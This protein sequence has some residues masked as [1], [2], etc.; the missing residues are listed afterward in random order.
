LGINNVRRRLDLA[1]P[2]RYLLVFKDEGDRYMVSMH[3]N[4]NDESKLFHN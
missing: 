3:I 2:E 1:Y 4:L